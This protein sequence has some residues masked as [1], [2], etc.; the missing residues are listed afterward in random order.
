[1]AIDPAGIATD[2]EAGPPTISAMAVAPRIARVGFGAEYVNRRTDVPVST[3]TDR[4]WDT[5]AGATPSIAPAAL[6]TAS[7]VGMTAA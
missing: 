5:V 3:T 4:E 7:S 6:N 1:M 2:A